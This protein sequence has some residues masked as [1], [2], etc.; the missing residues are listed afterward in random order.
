MVY[1][2]LVKERISDA[3]ISYLKEKAEVILGYD[4]TREDFLNILPE[5]HAL[6]VR[7][8]TKV[9]EEVLDKATNLKVVGRAGT[10]IDN[11]DIDA[12]TNRGI[13]VV[14]TP[15]SNTVSAAEHTIALMFALVRN[16]P[17][18]YLSMREG[19]W[20][21]KKFQGTELTGKTLGII[22]LGRIGYEVGVRA[23]GL[24]M[25]V[26]AFD[27]YIP[28]KRFENA[29][30][31]RAS[32][33]KELLSSSDIITIHVPKTKD[34]P[35]VIGEDEFEYI[36]EG[37][38]I[39]NCARGGLINEK[40][41]YEYL[42]KGKIKGAALDVFSEEPPKDKILFDLP[43]VIFTPHLGASTSEAQHRAGLSIAKSVL[44]ILNG[45]FAPHIVNIPHPGEDMEK[46]RD[47][48]KLAEVMGNLFIQISKLPV[49][50]ITIEYMGDIASRNTGMIGRFFLKEFLKPMV[51]D[52]VNYVNSSIIASRRGINVKEI[53]NPESKDYKNLVKVTGRSGNSYNTLAGTVLEE[54]DLRIVMIDD[55]PIDLTPSSNML[56]VTN[57]DKPGMI[58]KVGTILGNYNINI[59]GLRLGRIIKGDMAKIVLNLDDEVPRDVILEITQ[60]EGIVDAVFVKLERG[61]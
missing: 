40:L 10:G 3:A 41:L 45:K 18:A 39:I 59:A 16:I 25:E 33:L 42:K 9:T 6:I 58:G 8:G 50:E 4:F 34:K 53:S 54:G 61:N 57:M 35:E 46:I 37:A 51:Q 27:P 19:K 7:S 30:I 38:Y 48:I 15:D 43:N 20:D 56:I 12:A 28:D 24:K 32:D 2:I 60:Q 55:Y 22:G 17:Q 11:I 26:I 5:I 23:K 31:K 29:R 1:K 36:K 47:F 44:D 13:I 21:R 14:N 52:V 49:E